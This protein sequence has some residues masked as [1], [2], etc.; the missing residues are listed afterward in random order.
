[1][2]KSFNSIIGL[3]LMFCALGY[4]AWSWIFQTGLYAIL[5]RWQADTFNNYFP[6]LTFAAI[7]LA[8]LLPIILIEK[9]I[10]GSGKGLQIKKGD[11]EVSLNELQ[12][13]LKK[14][15]R[16]F[17]IG[18]FLFIGAALGAFYVGQN[19]PDEN[20]E[21][22][23]VDLRNFEEGNYWFKKVKLNGSLLTNSSYSITSKNNR[24]GHT[25]ET[26]YTPIASPNGKK[27][28]IHFVHLQT[29]NHNSRINPNLALTGFVRPSVLPVLV[30]DTFEQDGLVMADRVH[31]IGSSVLSLQMTLYITTGFCGL[32]AFFLFFS[33][34]FSP[35]ARRRLTKQ[36]R[37]INGDETQR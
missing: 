7:F 21:T 24:R 18:M 23:S 4:A 16:H 10:G 33:F 5:I 22:I 12:A 34:I 27:S 19:A 8:L 35:I 13:R 2:K 6:T 25:S 29:S 28:P 30:R 20:Q 3:G 14:R 9:I 11:M 36:W 15:S 1:M 37:E 32:I 17:L 31:V 26:R